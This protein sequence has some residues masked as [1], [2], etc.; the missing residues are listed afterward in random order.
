MNKN[1]YPRLAASNLKKN[2][3]TYLPY[4][5]AS[6]FCIA[7]FY[8]INMLKDTQ[9]MKHNSLTEMLNLGNYVVAVFSVIFLFYTN[10]FLIKRRK[11]EF[12]L[13]NVLGMGKR[14]IAKIVFLES[15]YSSFISI[16]LGIGVG[17]LMSKLIYL[18]LEN[19]INFE[20][21]DKVM[22]SNDAVI[23]TIILFVVIFTLTLLNSLRLIHLSK[24]IELLKGGQKGEKEPKINWVL[25]VAGLIFLGIG[26]YM[27]VTIEDPLD[28]L[29]FFFVAVIFVI[30]GTYCL[31]TS[32]TV[33]ILKLL[34]KNKK[35][36]YKT[37]HF[38]SVS[39]M[40]YRMKQNAIGLANICILSTIVLVTIS[41]TVS[42]YTGVDE[43]MKSTYPSDISVTSYSEKHDEAIDD[44]IG[45]VLSQKN[46]KVS[47]MEELK[48]HSSVV[49]I[50]KNKMNFAGFYSNQ[51][52]LPQA[53]LN[54]IPLYEY[55]KLM[56]K[57]MDLRKD[58]A[59]IYSNTD[60][61]KGNE[62]TVG[63]MKFDIKIS[64]GIDKNVESAGKLKSFFGRNTLDSYYLIVK[65]MDV[66]NQLKKDNEE[67]IQTI[68]GEDE[69]PEEEYGRITRIVRFD[70]D[71]SD[72]EK[73]KLNAELDKVL[74]KNTSYDGYTEARAENVENFYEIYGG[75]LFLG[76]Y[77]GILFLMATIL[78][79]YYKQISEGYEDKERFRIMQ[80]V[81]LTKREV[82]KAIRSQV[83][84]MF[85]MPLIVAC[86]HIIFAFPMISK[87]LRLFHLTN[88]NL[89]VICTLVCAGI[90]AV[91]YVLVYAF[92]SRLYYKIVEES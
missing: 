52:D 7:M 89:F 67:A 38:I 75:L 80:N 88:T 17:I 32:V 87:L 46:Y 66:V 57:D 39:S 71:T 14:H 21:Q 20:L 43:I 62:L 51:S 47:N 34:R 73:V 45:Q 60:S 63:K 27:A 8:I 10:S 56:G 29:L 44:T 81:G 4:I 78:I 35:Y 40:I 49:S 65:D 85:F 64:G 23:M 6:V 69:N 1:F 76:M 36:Y 70:V 37:N 79:I 9:F 16:I 31:F 26:Y 42:L 12:G 3:R 91:F 59:L 2:S 48:F 18:I 58:D 5:L 13:F 61:Y 84:T 25:T 68:V 54:I 77:L 33:F 92:T 86:V 50:E 15:L 55:N 24:P 83:L 82:R 90:F 30:L 22:V 28:A 53:T 11:K 72:S 41:T 74:S 19:M